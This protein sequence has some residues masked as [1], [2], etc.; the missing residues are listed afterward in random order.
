M[1]F[2]LPI[3]LLILGF[4]I[5]IKGADFLVDGAV[6]LAHK[7]RIS[8]MVIGL[9]IVAFGTSAPE[10]VVNIVASLNQQ[11]DVVIGNIIGSNIGNN[12]LILGISSLIFPLWVQ[13]NTVQKEIPFAFIAVLLVL[14]LGNDTLIFKKSFNKLS[15]IDGFIFLGFFVF[16]SFYTFKMAKTPSTQNQENPQKNQAPFSLIKTLAFLILGFVGL[17]FGGKL[18]VKNAVDLA[19]K[20]G[21]SQKLIAL[22][23]ISIGTSLPELAAS[24]VAAFKKKSDLAIGNIVGSNIFNVFLVLGVSTLVNPIAYDTVFN[25]DVLVNAGATF[26][27]F[28]FMF[29]GK[30]FYLG[31]IK[32]GVFFIGYVSYIT[33]L[34]IRN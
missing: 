5:L 16:F 11:P 24:S 12:L 26:L 1:E 17:F 30:R 33:F 27:L 32:G 4:I 19:T 28:I 21:L 34:I 3:G 15:L 8:E 14:F 20:L 13:K 9:T 31:R 18:V 10:L 7:A 23:I 6:A 2:L 22:T 29:L 25:A